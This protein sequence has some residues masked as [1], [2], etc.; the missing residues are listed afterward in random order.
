ML[1][2]FLAPVVDSA[3]FAL[4]VRDDSAELASYALSDRASIQSS[5]PP[6]RR[7]TQ[8]HLESFFDQVSES[9]ITSN[10]EL[11][12][13]RDNIIHEVSEPT[14]P[15][16]ETT[17]TKSPSTSLLANSLRRSPPS[18]SPPD[19]DHSN[20]EDGEAHDDEPDMSQGRLIITSNGV[21]LDAT[22]RTP[23]VPKPNGFLSSNI[24]CL[25]GQYDGEDLEQQAPKKSSSWSKALDFVSW[26]RERSHPVSKTVFN[27][28]KWDREVITESL[29]YTPARNLP[30][31]V[32]GALL[33]ILDALSYGTSTF[34]LR[35]RR[36]LLD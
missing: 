26:P 34:L 21:K 1:I 25:G 31:A 11:E 15:D 5:S 36:S 3:Q 28:R 23:L 2:H 18:R 9:E 7:L 33:N 4:S 6:P 30:A 20:T 8:S 35:N 24:Y 14:S 13:V 27:P 32:L 16:S 19:N 10:R 22:E 29:I 12:R 17:P